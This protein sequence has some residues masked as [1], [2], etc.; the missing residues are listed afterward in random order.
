MDF[1]HT[2]GNR[3][4]RDFARCLQRTTNLWPQVCDVHVQ[5]KHVAAGSFLLS[6]VDPGLRSYRVVQTLGAL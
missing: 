3:H 6:L 5:R 1:G 2:Y 4:P